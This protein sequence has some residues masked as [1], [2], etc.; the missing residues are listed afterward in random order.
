MLHCHQFLFLLL[1]CKKAITEP[2]SRQEVCVFPAQDFV[3]TSEGHHE[4][5]VGRLLYVFLVFKDLFIIR[6]VFLTSNNDLRVV[7]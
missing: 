4:A 7:L 1:F 2:L 3:S 5:T 6:V